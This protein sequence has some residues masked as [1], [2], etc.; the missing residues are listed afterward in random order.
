[1]LELG[2][3]VSGP[4]PAQW[5]TSRPK[6]DPADERLVGEFADDG[7]TGTWRTRGVDDAVADEPLSASRNR[8]V[9]RTLQIGCVLWM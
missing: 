4:L 7:L 9:E 8:V 2:D 5:T 6:N 3:P 1:M